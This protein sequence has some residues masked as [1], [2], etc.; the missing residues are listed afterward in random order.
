MTSQLPGFRCLFLSCQQQKK[1]QKPGSC[2]VIKVL[3][4]LQR[5]QYKFSMAVNKAGMSSSYPLFLF[6]FRH[7]RKPFLDQP[8]V[9]KPCIMDTSPACPTQAAQ[10]KMD[11]LTGILNLRSL[12]HDQ[13]KLNIL[14]SIQYIINDLNFKI[15]TPQS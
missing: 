9:K 1:H 4:I 8:T 3:L 7:K 14:P 15:L 13:V 12:E 11:G 2:E 5:L 10:Q 6:S